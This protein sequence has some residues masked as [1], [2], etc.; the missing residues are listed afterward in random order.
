M[1][2]SASRRGV[3]LVADARAR[4]D[5]TLVGWASGNLDDIRVAVDRSAETV[6]V[7]I[8]GR[9]RRIMR[10]YLVATALTGLIDGIL[11]GLAERGIV[12]PF[13]IGFIVVGAAL[14][15]RRTATGDDH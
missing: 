5:A 9:A 13:L 8:T 4:L 6:S 2:S 15:Q 12:Y 11:I 10:L 1:S 3:S 14:R 7:E